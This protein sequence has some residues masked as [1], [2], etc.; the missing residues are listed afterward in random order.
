VSGE[1]MQ[2]Y[3]DLHSAHTRKNCGS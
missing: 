3:G 1:G 2:S